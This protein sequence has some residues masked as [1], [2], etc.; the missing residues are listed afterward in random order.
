VSVGVVALD[1]TVIAVDA[2]RAATQT[3]STEGT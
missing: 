1:G 2:S 3:P